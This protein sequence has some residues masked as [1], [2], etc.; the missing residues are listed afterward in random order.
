MDSCRVLSSA[1][2]ARNGNKLRRRRGRTIRIKDNR[3]Y[4]CIFWMWISGINKMHFQLNPA[5]WIEAYLTVEAEPRR[6]RLHGLCV[7]EAGVHRLT[8]TDWQTEWLPSP[9]NGL[10]PPN[11]SEVSLNHVRFTENVQTIKRDA[12]SK[13]CRAGGLS[14]SPWR[15]VRDARD[16]SSL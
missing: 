12:E 10:T 16:N 14:S 2:C 3:I 15:P 9:I 1:C 11:V 6:V 5:E 8:L 13:W 7:A 4:T